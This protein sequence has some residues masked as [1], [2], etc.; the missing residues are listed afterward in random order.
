MFLLHLWGPGQVYT[1]VR[2]CLTGW[3]EAYLWLDRGK[4]QRKGQQ[5]QQDEDGGS[6]QIH[7]THKTLK[8]QQLSGRETRTDRERERDIYLQ[9]H[10][11]ESVGVGPVF[12]WLRQVLVIA[13]LNTLLLVDSKFCLLYGF[14]Y[15]TLLP[16]VWA[17]GC[18]PDPGWGGELV[19]KRSSYPLGSWS[20]SAWRNNMGQRGPTIRWGRRGGLV[21]CQLGAC[22]SLTVETPVLQLFLIIF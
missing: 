8:S 16:P 14:R 20:N 3:I 2:R 10:L 18:G 22:W 5:R 12:V 13:F 6:P 1:G 19:G 17:G 7:Q 11:S 21:W 4:L 15:E 9:S